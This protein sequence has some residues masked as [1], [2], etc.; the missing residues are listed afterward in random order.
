MGL[1]SPAIIGT[2]LRIP[3]E[4]ETWDLHQCATLSG[5]G[6]EIDTNFISYPRPYLEK[7]MADIV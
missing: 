4:N 6:K 7:P 3:W 5:E 2:G 1:V